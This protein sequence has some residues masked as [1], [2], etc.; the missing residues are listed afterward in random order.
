M[1]IVDNYSR[2]TWVIFTTH[3]NETFANFEAFSRKYQWEAGYFITII[4]INHDGE[5]ENK[6]FEYFCAQNG[7]TQNFSSTSSPITKR[8]SWTEKQFTTDNATKMLFGRSL[9]DFFG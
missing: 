6:A 7:F 1:I 8:S 3:K 9:P 4:H 2:F 5:F